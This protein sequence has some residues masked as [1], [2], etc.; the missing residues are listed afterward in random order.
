MANYFKLTCNVTGR[1]LTVNNDYYQKKITEY[2]SE[3][4]LRNRYV[5]K[6]AKNL[7]KKGYNI[8]EIRNMLKLDETN[9][10]KVSKEDMN[11]ITKS[12]ASTIVNLE[13]FS[14]KK[15]DPDVEIL[16]NNIINQQ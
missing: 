8:Q 12:L 5:C 14:V 16:I 4:L 2:G 13:N 1:E 11:A 3:E 9:L 6:Y 7:L 15:S 10:P